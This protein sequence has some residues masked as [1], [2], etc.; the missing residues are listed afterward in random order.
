MNFGP[1]DDSDFQFAEQENIIIV[2]NIV[3]IQPY[4]Q[5]S[6]YFRLSGAI[7]N[8]GV[9]KSS[10]KF[11]VVTAE[12]LTLENMSITFGILSLGGTESKIYLGGNLP[13]QLQRTF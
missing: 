4:M 7:L 6:N 2:S 5:K 9:K 13:T 10:V 11:G 12:K 3:H 8:F 1:N